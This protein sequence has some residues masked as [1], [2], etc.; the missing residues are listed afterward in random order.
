MP[1]QKVST[2]DND[3]VEMMT[4]LN[5]I[6]ETLNQAVDVHSVL[7]YTLA[8]LVNLMGLE[9]GWIMLRNHSA[10]DVGGGSHYDL[11]AHHNLP[12]ALALDD[13]EVW[14]RPCTCQRLCDSGQLSQA[15]NEVRCSRL[16]GKRD[17]QQGLAVHASVPLRSA[18]RVLGI[19]SVAAPAWDSFSPKNLSLLTNV[20]SQMGIALERAQLYDQLR[21]QRT[22]EQESLIEF[23]QQLLSRRNLADLMHYLVQEIRAVLGADACALLLPS[24]DA[25]SLEFRAAS[26]W[27]HDPSEGGR[28]VPATGESGP[29]QVMKT[30]QPLMARDLRE[31]DPTPWS[32]DWLSLED[33]RGHTVVPLLSNSHAVGVLVVNQRQPRA[34]HQDDLRCLLMMANQ[35]AVALEQGR[36]QAE[37]LK[38]QAMEKELELGRRIQ[39][40]LLPDSPPVVPG[41]EFAVFYQAAREVG[42]DFYDF[43]ELPAEPGKIGFVIADVIGKGVPAA[44][45][46]AR[47][48][49]VIRNSALS[50]RSPSAALVRANE[51]TLRDNDMDPLLTALYGVLDTTTGRLEYANA[52]HCR[53]LWVRPARG[54]VEELTA[55]GILLG[56]FSDIVLEERSVELD[57]GDLILFFTDGVTEAMN[58]SREP[59]DNE[60]LR[61]IVSAHAGGGARQLLEAIVAAVQSYA[62]PKDQSDDI[63][64]FVFKRLAP[65][66]E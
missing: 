22:L 6:S 31:Q 48:S 15:Y 16:A 59:F 32:P 33:F 36:L 55:G 41:W 4:A 52:G 40:G 42:G 37:E 60:R 51:L 12:P 39:L 34:M 5:H 9:S 3:L 18:D 54:Q 30:H 14:A 63:S 1:K 24:T 64:L 45:S 29:G 47:S 49:M 50:L 62:N 26:G 8:E 10:L 56:A 23:S 53:P 28:R 65:E 35:A 25:D 61:A 20:G 46:M 44:L 19:L 43:F 58:A 57:H 7:E 2:S 11:V 38:M 21:A 17:G 66:D 13:T 27:R